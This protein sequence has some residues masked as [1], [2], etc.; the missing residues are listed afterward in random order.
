LP[1]PLSADLDDDGLADT[2]DNDCNGVVNDSDAPDGFR[3]PRVLG[4][5]DPRFHANVIAPGHFST[6]FTNP[7]LIRFHDGAWV[8]PGLE[9]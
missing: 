3:Q 2:T 6:A 1:L 9:P 7:F 8:A 5:T 4:E